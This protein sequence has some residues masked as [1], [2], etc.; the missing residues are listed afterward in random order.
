MTRRPLVSVITPAYNTRAYVGR[1]VRSALAQSVGNLEVIVVDDGST[2]GTADAAREC[3]R[4]DERVRI[5]RQDNAGPSAARNT[6]MRL[7]AGEFF[8]WLDS[9]DEWLPGF[10]EAQLAAFER[11][12]STAIVTA[13]AINRGGA[14]DGTLYRP[15]RAGMRPLAFA[16]L[17]REEDAVCVLSVFRREVYDTVGPM[18]EA[19]RSN[20]DYEFWL[21]AALR[22]CEVVQTFEPLAYYC[23]RPDNAT[24]DDHK[25]AAGILRVFRLVRPSC[26]TDGERAAVDTQ[27]ARYVRELLAIEGRAALKQADFATAA[28]RF[29]ELHEQGGG[30][31]SAA[32]SLAARHTPRLLYWAAKAR[33]TVREMGTSQVVRKE[34]AK[35]G[36]VR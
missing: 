35:K 31:R 9:D 17:I 2:D 34:F 5:V 30:G 4:D 21:R 25:M 13:N 12:P 27:I 14:F 33:R 15:A 11:R 8:A 10:L 18:N 16:D 23:R 36:N 19:L 7:A 28:E 3:A 29:A 22:G 24:S 32:I 20:E 26:R 1:A 6:A